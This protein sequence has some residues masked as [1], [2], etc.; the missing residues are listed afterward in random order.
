LKAAILGEAGASV[1]EVDIIAKSITRPGTIGATRRE[2]A[3]CLI[4]SHAIRP[5]NAS[6]AEG[7]P[8]VTPRFVK[9]RWRLGPHII[10][11][12]GYYKGPAVGPFSSQLE[13]NLQRICKGFSHGQD[14]RMQ[15]GEVIARAM[16]ARQL[17]SYLPDG[18]RAIV[19]RDL[20]RGS[21]QCLLWF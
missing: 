13:A 7:A 2:D 11:R 1:E 19:F 20:A 9:L 4:Q 21:V 17:A 8:P 10:S 6:H 5:R 12:I 18:S 15:A 3:L 16:L 14:Q